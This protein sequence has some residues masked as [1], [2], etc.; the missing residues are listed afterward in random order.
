MQGGFQHRDFLTVFNIPISLWIQN[1]THLF[2]KNTQT[3][4]D[5]TGKRLCIKCIKEMFTNNQKSSTYL[6]Q[7]CEDLMLMIKCE[8]GKGVVRFIINELLADESNFI[9]EEI[10][11]VDDEMLLNNLI[12]LK[13]TLLNKHFSIS[14]NI[15]RQKL[16]ENIL[17]IIIKNIDNLNTRMRSM[18]KLIYILFDDRLSIYSNS[19]IDGIVEDSKNLSRFG[20]IISRM[21]MENIQ[22]LIPVLFK[23][24]E[25]NPEKVISN[26]F[27]DKGLHLSKLLCEVSDRKIYFEYMLEFYLHILNNYPSHFGYLL[28]DKSYEANLIS[29]NKEELS[30]NILN[31]IEK[32]TI[33]L[34]K[35]S[36]YSKTKNDH[37]SRNLNIDKFQN[38]EFS[39]NDLECMQ[40]PGSIP[41]VGNYLI[42]NNSSSG[43]NRLEEVGEHGEKGLSMSID[44]FSNGN[45]IYNSNNNND[46]KYLSF[47]RNNNI[48]INELEKKK[49]LDGINMFDLLRKREED[50][51]KLMKKLIEFFKG[52]MLYK[53]KMG[54]YWSSGKEKLE[55]IKIDEEDDD[56]DSNSHQ[57]C[58]INEWTM[59]GESFEVVHKIIEWIIEL[60]RNSIEVDLD[61]LALDCILEIFTREKCCI[62]D[63][64]KPET[65]EELS[66]LNNSLNENNTLDNDSN[67]S[68]NP[69]LNNENKSEDFIFNVRSLNI[70]SKRVTFK[71]TE[72]IPAKKKLITF[73]D[74]D[75]NKLCVNACMQGG[76]KNVSDT[77]KEKNKSCGK[78]CFHQ[79]FVIK[80]G[81]YLLDIFLELFD[82]YLRKFGLNY[83]RKK[84]GSK[85]N[86]PFYDKSYKY[87]IDNEDK[88]EEVLNKIIKGMSN[89]SNGVAIQSFPR[90]VFA[91]S[92]FMDFILYGFMNEESV[93]KRKPPVPLYGSS[94]MDM[95]M[96]AANMEQPLEYALLSISAKFS[97]ENNQS[98]EKAQNSQKLSINYVDNNL[99]KVQIQ[100]VNQIISL[101]EKMCR[102][103][104]RKG[105]S[106]SKMEGEKFSGSFY[107]VDIKKLWKL[108]GTVYSRDLL[109][110]YFSNILQIIERLSWLK[111]IQIIQFL[112]STDKLF[113]FYSRE[114]KNREQNMISLAQLY[115]IQHVF[116]NNLNF[117]FEIKDTCLENKESQATFI[118]NIF[119]IILQ[120]ERRIQ[121]NLEDFDEVNDQ[122]LQKAAKKIK[123]L[124]NNKVGA[125]LVF[126]WIKDPNIGNQEIYGIKTNILVRWVIHISRQLLHPIMSENEISTRLKYLTKE[127][128][129]AALLLDDSASSDTISIVISLLTFCYGY[130]PDQVILFILKNINR[131]EINDSDY[132]GICD[133]S[134]DIIQKISNY[135]KPSNFGNLYTG[136]NIPTR[137]LLYYS[138]IILNNTNQNPKNVDL[139]QD[140]FSQKDKIVTKIVSILFNSNIRRREWLLW[141]SK[142]FDK[143]DLFSDSLRN[144]IQ[145]RGA[146]GSYQEQKKVEEQIFKWIYDRNIDYSRYQVSTRPF[147]ITCFYSGLV[148]FS[149]SPILEKSIMENMSFIKFEIKQLL[150]LSSMQINTCNEYEVEEFIQKLSMHF[151]LFI[152]SIQSYI[153]SNNQFEFADQLTI[154]EA[155]LPLKL[156]L[157]INKD[158]FD[159]K[160]K[161]IIGHLTLKFISVFF[162]PS[163]KKTAFHELSGT[164]SSSKVFGIKTY[165]S[166]DNFGESSTKKDSSILFMLVNLIDELTRW[167]NDIFNINNIENFDI[168]GYLETLSSLLLELGLK[169]NTFSDCMEIGA[170][171]EKT[172]LLRLKVRQ[173]LINLVQSDSMASLVEKI[174]NYIIICR[175][176]G[177]NL[178][179]NK[180]SHLM[181][182]LILL[183]SLFL[184][185]IQIFRSNGQL[186]S[187]IDSFLAHPTL[188]FHAEKSSKCEFSTFFSSEC[189]NWFGNLIKLSK[190]ITTCDFCLSFGLNHNME[191]IK[192]STIVSL[193]VVLIRP[194]QVINGIISKNNLIKDVFLQSISGIL[195]TNHKVS[196]LSHGYMAIILASIYLS[197]DQIQSL[198]LVHNLYIQKFLVKEFVSSILN[199]D[200]NPMENLNL[201]PC[202]IFHYSILFSYLVFILKIT[203]WWFNISDLLNLTFVNRL[204]KIYKSLQALAIIYND[205]NDIIGEYLLSLTEIL[206]KILLETAKGQSNFSSTYIQDE[207]KSGTGSNGVI[208]KLIQET[209]KNQ[210]N[211]NIQDYNITLVREHTSTR[212][213]NNIK[214]IFNCENNERSGC[215][216]C[217]LGYQFRPFE[218]NDS[219]INN[220]FINQVLKFSTMEIF[221]RIIEN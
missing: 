163:W 143:I 64:E 119:S 90:Q 179:A 155:T 180:L 221:K 127:R 115:L 196:S 126:K 76:A 206:L 74:V 96:K 124:I 136:R 66:N 52:F 33:S 89:I 95:V 29:N 92:W 121:D 197:C 162:K 77:G 213:G 87:I 144:L 75:K 103:L 219:L 24:I 88:I 160:L 48:D 207:K 1:G 194:N 151:N 204:G 11:K 217:G 129:K 187:I 23:L 97:E 56:L 31:G 183:F 190:T 169:D 210:E 4:I 32:M 35:S 49:E 152:F 67:K 8:R 22:Y 85:Q 50:D 114:L 6:S 184:S 138:S 214:N 70:K 186:E 148:D 142:D 167:M 25:C 203:P 60:L 34:A 37:L 112:D 21:G 72:E 3:L 43:S 128:I 40:K 16:N 100:I 54:L 41:I 145:A 178:D 200:K 62:Y 7:I 140:Y 125:Q 51:N 170:G 47:G 68:P 158:D 83:I 191:E 111:G 108:N 42:N 101:I 17:N 81:Q 131:E 132:L 28:L 159:F 106:N 99:S 80:H 156:F 211:E 2:H 57:Y 147:S 165:K 113:E 14:E 26:L 44:N 109:L 86:L 168:S 65:E 146:I 69:E 53:N 78:I 123:V 63:E 94:S 176:K 39:I 122:I 174:L 199:F 10:N 215:F 110:E 216:I 175:R 161:A 220:F 205:E 116:D 208:I 139:F 218:T 135:G 154:E 15:Q 79:I 5:K 193:I 130:F 185:K 12:N 188:L 133:I 19:L 73:N 18:A 172:K 182:I 177:N 212:D 117:E 209:L 173:S 149:I 141:H 120:I 13:L 171:G 59:N 189:D 198:S 164:D 166:L 201:S 91:L 82:D 105:K 153:E 98:I 30:L 93:I 107:K 202:I 71:R 27:A 102:C 195:N 58:Q 61:N 46:E 181:V 36:R 157:N 118:Y 137:V 134:E 55:M 150:H 20:K 84:S 45:N 38:S 192:L 104:Y 9:I